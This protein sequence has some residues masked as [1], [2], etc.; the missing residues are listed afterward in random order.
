MH[1]NRLPFYLRLVTD[2]P[3]PR[4]GGNPPA[5]GSGGDQ[6]GEGGIKALQNERD[7][8][9]AAE[10]AYTDAK[11]AWEAEKTTLSQQLASVTDQSTKALAEAQTRAADAEAKVLRLEVAGAKGIP[12]ELAA[13]LIGTTREELE[14]DAEKLKTHVKSPFTPPYDPS[15]GQGHEGKREGTV[16]SGRDLYSELHSKKS[17]EK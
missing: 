3:E 6:L 8:R 7:A 10:K 16:E 11:A 4:D 12:S 2:P 5:G 9:K 17:K 13:R 15:R 14:S 1:R